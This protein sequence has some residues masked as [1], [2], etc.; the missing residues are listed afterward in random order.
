MV[1]LDHHPPT[2][3]CSAGYKYVHLYFGVNL[4]SNTILPIMKNYSVNFFIITCRLCEPFFI[5]YKKCFPENGERNDCNTKYTLSMRKE[6]ASL[7]Q[8]ER[9][10]MFYVNYSRYRNAYFLP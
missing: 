7:F 8:F 1:R 4:T 2:A 3:R 5:P 9:R 10:L 6:I